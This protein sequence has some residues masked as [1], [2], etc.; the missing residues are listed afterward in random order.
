MSMLGNKS[1]KWNHEREHRIGIENVSSLVTHDYRASKSIMF[2]AYLP[3]SVRAQVYQLTSQR[4]FEFHEIVMPPNEY[5][6]ERKII[7]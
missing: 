1:A 6:L 7:N 5:I 3:Q 4:V 2:R